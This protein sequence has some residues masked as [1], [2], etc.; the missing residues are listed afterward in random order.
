MT[1][2]VIGS[3]I[4]GLEASS[5][6]SMKEK[7]VLFEEKEIGGN[8][9]NKT[10]IPSKLL[11]NLSNEYKDFSEIKRRAVHKINL[12]RNKILRKL[13]KLGVGIEKGHVEISER[14]I[15]F[16]NNKVEIKDSDSIL[17]CTGSI[18]IEPIIIGSEHLFYSN[19]I[20]DL[21][22]IPSRIAIIGAGPEGVEFAHLFNSL[23]SF[24][25]II[26]KKSRILPSEDEEISTIM[27]S[28]LE[29]SGINVYLNREVKGI[30]KDKV[31]KVFLNEESFEFD[32][33]LSCIGW[34]PNLNAIKIEGFKIDDHLRYKK[35]IYVA[36]DAAN[37]GLANI[38]KD[39]ARIA[40]LNA[41]GNNLKFEPKAY[42]YVIHCK[43]KISAFKLKTEKK[44]AKILKIQIEEGIKD[45]EGFMKI[46][47]DEE[48]RIISAYCLSDY[49]DEVI[50]FLA[51]SSNKNLKIHELTS[52][53]PRIP[54]Y[55]EEVLDSIKSAL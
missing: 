36:G 4:A 15:S 2:Y 22:E 48:D 13:E 19:L 17:I 12:E 37:A 18:P 26:E 3:G 44:E 39:Q 1:I 14:Y 49:S 5:I 55:I 24:V 38:A 21:E 40:A 33:V 9:L 45:G 52:F 8:Y 51:F 46:F 7:T 20:L 34:K 54:S 50:D 42:P 47:L 11:I 41:L 32:M 30:K 53:F 27:K 29:A 16:N 23:G 31:Y 43:P 10:C 28:K 6:S 25:S 35:N